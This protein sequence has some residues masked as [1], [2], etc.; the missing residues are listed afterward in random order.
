MKQ[1]KGCRGVGGRCRTGRRGAFRQAGV[2]GVGRSGSGRRAGAV[3]VPGGS[4]NR[5]HGPVCRAVRTTFVSRVGGTGVQPVVAG[6]IAGIRLLVVRRDRCGHGV[7]R[8]DEG[9]IPQ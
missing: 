2:D 9:Q 7:R 6:R 3:G 4:T 5:R 1:S 8:R